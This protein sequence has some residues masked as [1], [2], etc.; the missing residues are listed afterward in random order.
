[1]K[2]LFS[3]IV[4]VMIY[5]FTPEDSSTPIHRSIISFSIESDSLGIGSAKALFWVMNSM[6]FMYFITLL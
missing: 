4:E 6:I 1:M 2:T 5:F 3:K